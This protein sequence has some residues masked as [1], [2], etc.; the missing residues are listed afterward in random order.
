MFNCDAMIY[1]TRYYQ[2]TL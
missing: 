1:I 2:N